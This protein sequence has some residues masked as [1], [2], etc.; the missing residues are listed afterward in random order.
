MMM[1]NDENDENKIENLFLNNIIPTFETLNDN[2]LNNKESNHLLNYV[3]DFTENIKYN[4]I[5]NNWDVV[6]IEHNINENNDEI[7]ENNENN[8]NEII[9]NVADDVDDT[10]HNINENNNNQY[11]KNVAK[12]IVRSKKK[13]RVIYLTINEKRKATMLASKKYRQNQNQRKKN[14]ELNNKTLKIENKQ[15]KKK[16]LLL[17]NQLKNIKIEYS[18]PYIIN[19]GLK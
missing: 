1:Y 15:L 13:K 7:I 11:E 6:Y 4:D 14:I 17:K 12:K 19:N 3:F 18:I 10:E 8:N 16:N 9:E 2:E 5:D